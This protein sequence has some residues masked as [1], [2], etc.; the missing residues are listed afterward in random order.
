MMIIKVSKITIKTHKKLT[1]TCT[2]PTYKRAMSRDTI[3]QKTVGI[4]GFFKDAHSVHT[5]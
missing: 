2:K 5:S 3:K 1:K 4:K